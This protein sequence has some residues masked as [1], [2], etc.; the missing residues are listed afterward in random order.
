MLPCGSDNTDKSQ[1]KILTVTGDLDS[2]MADLVGDLAAYRPGGKGLI[3]EGGGDSE[4]DRSFVGAV[5]AAELSG[6]NLI[7]GANKVRVKA[8]HEILER[9]YQRGDLP[10]KFYAV[11]DRDSPSL[12]EEAKAIN[13][14]MW[15]VY[16]V[17]NYLLNPEI[18]LSVMKVLKVKSLNSP[19]EI[20]TALEVA[21]H[22]AVAP[23]ISHRLRSYANEVLVGA[24][25]LG[26]S[27]SAQPASKELH[28]AVTRSI[29]RIAVNLGDSLSEAALAA[30]EDH[31]RQEVDAS[32]AN[33]DWLKVIPGREILKQFIQTYKIPV[34]YEV[35]RNLLV[36]KMVETGFKPNG[37]SEIISK[38]QAD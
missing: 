10:T 25:N 29:D 4:F 36:G 31:F 14:F 33:S 19:A 15:D 34:S 18:I 22:K 20:L 23:L 38:I 2:A 35:L 13:R 37:M 21:A 8:L 3:F 9:A 30:K 32:F 1:L 11:V 6:I 27:P 26:Y 24:I 17:E 16:H 12:Q 5:F 7:S 28:G